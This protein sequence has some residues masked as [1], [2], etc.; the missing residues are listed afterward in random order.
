MKPQPLAA[1]ICT[2]LTAD[3]YLKLSGNGSATWLQQG[4]NLSKTGVHTT[5][6][7]HETHAA[8]LK[9]PKVKVT[10]FA[11]TP[12]TLNCPYTHKSPG[13]IVAFC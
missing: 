5:P 13:L 10:Y 3:D 12:T 1:G 6:Q 9:L 2:P 7:H 11:S 8:L 4:T